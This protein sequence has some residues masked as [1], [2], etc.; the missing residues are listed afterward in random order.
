MA[1][2]TIASA[3]L[4]GYLRSLGHPGHWTATALGGGVSNSVFLAECGDRRWVVKQ[5]LAK[6]RVEED[7]FADPARIHRECAAIDK[8]GP[9][10][11]PGAVPKV[12]FEDRD[13]FIYAMEA[14]P[15]GSVD[16]KSLLLR[17]EISEAVARRAGAILRAVVEVSRRSDQWSREFG[18]QACFDQLR[19]DP[20]YRFTASRHPDLAD[21]FQDRIDACGRNRTSL[22]HGDFSPKNLLVSPGGEM[23]LIDF[24]VIHFGDPAFDTAFL[25]NHLALK[26]AHR[27]QDAAAYQRAAAAFWSEMSATVSERDTILHLGCLQLARVDGKS[28]AEYLTP[29]ERALVRDQARRMILSPPPHLP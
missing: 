9:L 20:Y 18:D 15:R 23:T 16:W 13:N 26:S 2:V 1:A 11:P 27:P 7:W 17:G 8:L 4:A 29:A 24:E 14:A 28:P 12:V 21:R 3:N 22:V 5:A 25:L 6:L 19:L 10:L